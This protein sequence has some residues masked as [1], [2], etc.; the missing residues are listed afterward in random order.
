[1]K[2]GVPKTQRNLQ[3]RNFWTIPKTLNSHKVRL[4]SVMKLNFSG[5]SLIETIKK[6]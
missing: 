6:I 3:T 2:V 5:K 1:M 4:Y